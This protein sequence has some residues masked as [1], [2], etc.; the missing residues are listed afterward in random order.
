MCTIEVLRKQYDVIGTTRYNVVSDNC[1]IWS[2]FCDEY[3]RCRA[4]TQIHE[5]VQHTHR[6]EPSRSIKMNPP[7]EIFQCERYTNAKQIV[8]PSEA[9]DEKKESEKKKKKWNKIKIKP[10]NRWTIH[11]YERLSAVCWQ[12]DFRK[13]QN[14]LN[15]WKKNWRWIFPIVCENFLY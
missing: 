2:T 9:E 3:S 7:N 14:E 11:W 8:R 1:A 5:R 4:H 13:S 12:F 15:E 10:K 6:I